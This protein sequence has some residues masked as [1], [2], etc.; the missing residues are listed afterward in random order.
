MFDVVRV[1][2]N[3]VHESARDEIVNKRLR[4]P[5]KQTGARCRGD[6]QTAPHLNPPREVVDAADQHAIPLGMRN[7]RHHAGPKQLAK[8]LAG[9]GKNVVF[10]K[11][12][13]QLVLAWGDASYILEQA[14]DLAGPWTTA[15]TTSPYGF[16]PDKSILQRFFRLKR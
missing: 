13:N 4:P 6:L 9:V 5:A 3:K 10:G 12:D 14:N 7:H 11:F 16:I 15:A 2:C 8:D 1:A